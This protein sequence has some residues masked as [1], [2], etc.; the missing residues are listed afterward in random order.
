MALV[1]TGGASHLDH[2]TVM[3]SH[4]ER[5]HITTAVVL[6][7]FRDGLNDLNRA[8]A[9]LR[10]VVPASQRDLARGARGPA[11]VPSLGLGVTLAGRRKRRPPPRPRPYARNALPRSFAFYQGEH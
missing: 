3:L 9:R 7:R 2:L 10:D 8:L 1:V 11:S 4:L 6:D 5:V